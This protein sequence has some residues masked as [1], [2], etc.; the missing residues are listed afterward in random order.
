[1]DVGS[2]VSE[3]EDLQAKKQEIIG[4]RSNLWKKVRELHAELLGINDEYLAV[5][6]QINLA[7]KRENDRTS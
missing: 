6:L 1:M 7:E 5:D 4:R 3:L 2:A